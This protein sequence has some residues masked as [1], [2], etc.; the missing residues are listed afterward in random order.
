MR[1]L[2]FNLV[3]CGALSALQMQSV[4]MTY[5]E[6][7]DAS[8]RPGSSSAASGRGDIDLQLPQPADESLRVHTPQQ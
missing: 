7:F 8:P 5:Q 3:N 6:L 1:T 4:L 2:L